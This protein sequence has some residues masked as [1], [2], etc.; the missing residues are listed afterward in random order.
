MPKT[1]SAQEGGADWESG[2]AA[3]AVTTAAA[4]WLRDP[5][6]AH[7]SAY[8]KALRDVNAALGTRAT[9]NLSAIAAPI[10]ASLQAIKAQ[11]E[12][13][14]SM[15]RIDHEQVVDRY[16]TQATRIFGEIDG[17]VEVQ[18]DVLSTVSEVRD[19]LK[20]LAARVG[21][22]EEGQQELASR[23]N[24]LGEEV[25]T[26]GGRLGMVEEG[27]QEL[28][29]RV[30]NL[31]AR[32]GT[33]ESVVAQVNESVKGNQKILERWTRV[34]GPPPELRELIGPDDAP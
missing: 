5:T 3:D 18:R 23:V 26:H 7:L 20:K 32:V 19:G 30:A 14:G 34:Q 28:S 11:M 6:P 24:N 17:L 13:E 12:S 4:A 31:E 9:Q 27:Q 22:V 8:N 29:E 2:A 16:D 25:H 10:M 33:M 21:A 1:G 15:R